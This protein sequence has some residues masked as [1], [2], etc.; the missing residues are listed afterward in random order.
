MVIQRISRLKEHLECYCSDI[1]SA[2]H[3]LNEWKADL[4]GIIQ[5]Q[6][7]IKKVAAILFGY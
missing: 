6:S 5:P 1:H 2:G 3:H 4:D 7:T